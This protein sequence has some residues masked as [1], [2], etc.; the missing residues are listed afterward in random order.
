M[1]NALKEKLEHSVTLSIYGNDKD[2][3]EAINDEMF[4]KHRGQVKYFFYKKPELL[5]KKAKKQS[6][7]HPKAI[8]VDERLMYIGS[9]NISQNAM[10]NSVE[11]GVIIEDT[12]Q[13]IELKKFVNYLIEKMLISL[14][15]LGD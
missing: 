8:V 12:G 15:F 5:D 2:Q 9:A 3:I 4:H 10:K 7:Y 11:I 13:C 1:Y 6:L 14:S